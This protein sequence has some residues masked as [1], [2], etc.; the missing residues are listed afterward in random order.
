MNQQGGVLMK[1]WLGILLA[2]ILAFNL[3]PAAGEEAGI[4]NTEAQEEQVVYDYNDLTIGNPTQMNGQF[5]TAL[6]GSHTSD[7]DVRQLTAGYNL[8]RWDGETS[9]FRFDHTVVSGAAIGDDLD[10]NRRYMI[11]LY[12]DL[13]FSVGTRIDS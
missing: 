6:W 11:S 5:F 2:C 1:K 10:G 4:A 8:I 7:I 13:Y 9:L 12:K 3:F